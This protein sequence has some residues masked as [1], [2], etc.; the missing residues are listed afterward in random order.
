MFIR[1]RKSWLTWNTKFSFL[2][3]SLRAGVWSSCW[4]I[5]R[6]TYELP[7]SSWM[8]WE[9]E[10]KGTTAALPDTYKYSWIPQGSLPQPH[11]HKEEL[12][13][14]NKIRAI[15]IYT[16]AMIRYP[17]GIITSPERSHRCPLTK[18]SGGFMD[19]FTPQAA[20]RL[21][22][23]GW[24]LVCIRAIIQEKA[25]GSWDKLGSCPP[26]AEWILLAA[27]TQWWGTSTFSLNGGM[28]TAWWWL[29]HQTSWCWMNTR[30]MQQW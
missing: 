5:W 26:P 24:G 16:A 30:R 29:I 20:V 23:A 17:A 25:K 2:S 18:A 7:S 27:A 13:G 12:N 21:E 4:G 3:F 15:I 11:I 9:A 1:I 14:W 6:Q 10:P 8:N 28:V 22:E 19:G